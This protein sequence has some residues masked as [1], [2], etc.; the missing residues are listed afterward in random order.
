MAFEAKDYAISDIL[1]KSVFDIPR[2]Q[3]RYVWKKPHWQD[4]YEDIVFSIT[5]TKPHFVGSIVLEGEGKKDG[6]SYY[7]IIDGQ[8]RLTTITIVLL[9]I[10]KHFHENDMT[11]DFLG[12]IS[13]LQSKNNSNQDITILNSEYHVSLASLIRNMIALKDKSL[14]MA[15]FVE[16]N[17]LSKT[18]DK[19]IGDALRFFYSAIRDDVQQ[20]DNVQKRLREIRNAVLDMTAVKIVS[21]SEEDSYTIFEILNARGQELAAHELLKNYIMR[22]I[23]PTERRDDAKMMWEDMERAVGSSMDKFIKHYATHRFGD[24]RDKYNSPYQ[25]IQKATHGQNIGELFDDIKLKSEY[26]SKIIH[27]DKGEDGNCDEIEYAIFDFFRTKRF[28]QFRPVLLSLIHQRSL[29]KLS[30][31]K[32]ELTLKYIYNFFVCYTIIGEEKSNK[33]EDVVFKYARMLEDSYSD[34]LLQ[35]IAN[36][37]KRK[38][39]SY[40]WFLN[41]FKNVGWSNHYDL[42]KGEKNKTRVQII[43][44]V[45]ELFVS[46]AHNAHDFTVEHILPDSDGITNAQIGN[47]IPLEDALNRSCANKSLTDKCGFYEKS[48]FTSAR[49]IATRF[50]EKPFD[51]SKRTEYLAKLMYNNILELNQFDYSKD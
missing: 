11:D 34:E 6:L 5:E 10:M 28:E 16:A 36:N 35:E 30:S 43:L 2:N 45:I 17:T 46:Q 31:Q 27:P 50:R 1:N 29:G 32:Y 12:T 40:E 48:S 51:P 3:R 25:A 19:C 38:I 24:T 47:L 13:Y 33:L 22:Y 14:S 23:Q 9:A 37:L 26:Y 39:P 42:Y 15:S 49:G 21:S 44:E 8:Q 18:K 41:A 7:T 4:L 20:V